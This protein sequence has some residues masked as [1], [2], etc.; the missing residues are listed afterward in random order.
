MTTP[1]TAVCSIPEAAKLLNLSERR[2]L[3]FVTT[4]RIEARQLKREWVLSV[5]SVK[6]FGRKPRVTGRPKGR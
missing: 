1:L 2:V 3:M 6:A 4:G 5:A